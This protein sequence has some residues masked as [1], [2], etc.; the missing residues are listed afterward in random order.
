MLALSNAPEYSI[1]IPV[2]GNEA[3]LSQVIARLDGLART[4]DGPMEAV[5]VIDGSPDGSRDVLRRVLPE[6]DIASQVLELSRNF[7]SFSA[8]RVGLQAA[9]GRFV[10]VMAA[11]LQ[12][13]PEVV[14]AFF[15]ILRTGEADIALGRRTGRADPLGSRISS[16]LYWRFYRRVVNPDVP[17]G[18][19]D[20]FACSRQVVQQLNRFGE[21]H[22][23]LV[24]LLF[25]VGFRRAFVDYERRPRVSG[26]SGWT[27][28]RKF[29]YL[30]D[31]VYA[32]TDLPITLLQIIGVSGVIGSFL[33]GLVTL[34][35]WSVGN[36]PVPGYTPLILVLLLA[37]SAILLGLGVVGSYMWRTYE[38]GKQRPFAIVREQDEFAGTTQRE[39]EP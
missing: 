31:S 24:G 33:L 16:A 38:N 5:F 9:R 28:R 2:Y 3:T 19:V 35:A 20:V 1:V 29:R 22:T 32:F 17:E 30:L 18:G 25:W 6:S 26:S 8:I 21:V 23:S 27:F 13:P 12:E 36:I 37:T 7:G 4:L 15:E 10:A 39:V 34:V 11:D 14:T